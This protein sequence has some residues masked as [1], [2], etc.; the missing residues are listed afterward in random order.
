[1]VSVLYPQFLLIDEIIEFHERMI[2]E[3]GGSLGLRDR[4]LLESALQQ[5]EASFDGKFLHEDLASMAAAYLYHLVENHP[6]V[7]GNKR[8]GAAA[9][10]TF[11]H[12]NHHALPDF[13][14]EESASGQTPL[15][16]VVLGVIQKSIT[17]LQL[18]ALIRDWIA[19]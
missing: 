4:T 16:L 5:P 8:I 7:D 6:F 1:M 17:K 19:Q 3:H 11:L 14:D 2:N 15:E 9:C 10:A 12:L 13:L 18:A